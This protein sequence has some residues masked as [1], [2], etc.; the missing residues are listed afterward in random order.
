VPL[1]KLPERFWV[2]ILLMREA[3]CATFEGRPQTSSADRLEANTDF[4]VEKNWTVSQ[5]RKLRNKLR[6][7]LLSGVAVG[8]DTKRPSPTD[9]RVS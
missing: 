9:E 3:P 1:A 7:N 6:R 2:T 8:S 4:G 5:M